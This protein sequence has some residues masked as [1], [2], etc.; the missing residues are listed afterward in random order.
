MK[1]KFE[2]DSETNMLIEIIDGLDV[3]E[4]SYIEM[5]K[6]LRNENHFEESI[7]TEDIS[8]EEKERINSMLA[9][10]NTVITVKQDE[11]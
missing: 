11:Q 1:L 8:I 5:I 7:F 6:S 3:K 2:K 9:R 4:F 10:I